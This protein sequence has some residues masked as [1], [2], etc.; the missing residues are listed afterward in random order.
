MTVEL[1]EF[2]QVE[3]SGCPLVSLLLPCVYSD[4]PAELMHA[5]FSHL[6]GE[7]TEYSLPQEVLQPKPTCPLPQQTRRCPPSKRKDR[8][9]PVYAL[10]THRIG[11]AEGKERRPQEAKAGTYSSPSPWHLN[12]LHDLLC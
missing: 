4:H 1:E 6:S 8:C 12:E 2:F 5:L 9:L 10:L 11:E 7:A 3:F